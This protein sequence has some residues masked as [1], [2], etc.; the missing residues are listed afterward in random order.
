[1]DGERP[2]PAPAD[3]GSALIAAAIFGGA[4]VL[5][6]SMSSDA[7]RYQLAASGEVVVRMDSDSGEMIACRQQQ[8]CVR[9]QQPDRARTFGP[10]TV[11]IDD[12]KDAPALPAPNSTQPR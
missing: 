2:T 1:M 5:S 11:E 3:R 8:R 6:W 4:L 12:T 10:L 7:P 9:I